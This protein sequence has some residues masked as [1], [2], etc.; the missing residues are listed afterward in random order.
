MNRFFKVLTM[1]KLTLLATIS[2]F[3]SQMLLPANAAAAVTLEQLLQQVKNVRSAES[4]ENA[5]RIQEFT[6][7]RS[8][9][10]KLLADAQKAQKAAEDRSNALSAE[11]DKND[12]EINDVNQLLKQRQGNLGELFGVTRQVAGDTAN[13]VEQ[14][15]ISAEFPDREE[16]LRSLASA[17][18]LPSISE[19]ERLWFEMQREM[20]ATGQIERFEHPVLQPDGKSETAQV[21]RIG[22]FTEMSNGKYL[23]YLPSL[24]SLSVLSRQPP[25]RFLAAAKNFQAATTGYVRTA[26]DPGRGVLIQL[27]GERPD[28]VERIEQGQ[29][30]GYVIIA[31]LA[32]GLLCWV[33]QLIYLVRTRMK[34]AAQQKDLDHPRNDNPLG[35][36]LL[37]FKGDTS[38]IEEDWEVAELRISEAVVAEIPKLERFQAFLRLAVAAGPLLGLIGTVIGMILTFQS[39]TESGSSDPKLMAHGIGQA[40]IATVLGLACAIPLLFGNAV[41]SALSRQLTSLLD[42]QT[43]GLLAEMI[44]KKNAG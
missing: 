28:I 11:F 12:K 7:A 41:L 22:P 9:Q 2:L 36:V 24:K 4:T 16:F 1:R 31:V 26:V 29:E 43:S 30:V 8:E 5:K 32:A 37:A 3:A 6:A 21:V 42:G 18:A 25:S 19:L 13:V 10:A 17:K 15:I 39:I 40:M 33:Y 38:R 27:Y 34:V 23:T 44:E 14:S 20:T 35:R